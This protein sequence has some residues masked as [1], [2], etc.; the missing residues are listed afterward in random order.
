MGRADHWKKPWWWE[1]SRAGAEGGHRG[2]DGWMASPTQGTW[3]W[4]NSGREAW[5]AQSLGQQRVRHNLWTE[6]YNKQKS[7]P[8][9]LCEYIWRT[10]FPGTFW[11]WQSLIQSSCSVQ[12]FAT[13]WIAAYQASLSISSPPA[14]NTSQHQSLFQRVNSSHEVAKVLEFQL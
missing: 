8:E 12:L 6:Q 4:E 11:E 7:Y 9:G 13:P 5:C 1:R 10:F 2:W 14:P 3:V